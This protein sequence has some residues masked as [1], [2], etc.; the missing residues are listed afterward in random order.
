M[1]PRPGEPPLGAGESSSVPGTAAIANAI[2]DA[3]GVRFR[4]PP[5][6][7]EVVRA[8]LNPLA[9]PA[10][11]A[12]PAAP[13]LAPAPPTRCRRDARWPRAGG[14][15]PARWWPAS[16]GVGRRGARLAPRD[17]AGARPDA[18]HLHRRHDRARPP[19]RGARRLRA[20]ATPRPAARPTPAAA[21]WRRRSAR[22]TAPTSRP[23]SRPASARWS[24]SAFQRAMREGI[25]R[26]GHHLY[27]AFPYTAFTQDHRRRPD[28]AVRLP[29][30]AAGGA[31]RGA[32]DAAG[33][34]VQRAAAD[35]A[36]ER[37]VPDARAGRRRR[38]PRGR[39]EPRRLPGQRPRPLRRLPH[40][41][42]RARRRA[43]A[44]APSSPARW[45]KAGRR[46]R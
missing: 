13:A 41:A 36:V 26:D 7:P 21:R 10:A 11:G 22:S 24:F 38:R 12:G 19:A 9:G 45:S 16:L 32:A 1:M 15:A 17:R 2:F 34:S 43:A 4:Q 44:A 5:F 14:R 30:G 28:G 46:R 33:V 37:A 35:G 23:T 25:S 40:A 20:S 29:D 6:T 42:Q 18:P 3:T 31:Q 27:P 8:A 39:M